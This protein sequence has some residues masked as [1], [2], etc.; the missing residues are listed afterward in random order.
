MADNLGSKTIALDEQV[1]F[2]ADYFHIAHDGTR[3][4]C[5]FD[6]QFLKDRIPFDP[7]MKYC[8]S[9]V[10]VMTQDKRAILKPI[11]YSLLLEREFKKEK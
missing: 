6:G 4:V 10:G 7:P 2:I 8:L 9:S 1:E 11:Y 3:W 5:S